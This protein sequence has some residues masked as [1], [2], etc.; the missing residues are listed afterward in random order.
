[1][2]IDQTDISFTAFHTAYVGAIKVTRMSES[3]L[4]KSFIL[5]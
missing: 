5:A 4:G 2:N 3:F 1:M